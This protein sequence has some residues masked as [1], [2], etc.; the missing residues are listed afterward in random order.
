MKKK[1]ALENKQKKKKTKGNKVKEGKETIR[2][3]R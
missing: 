3:R 2:E 1:T